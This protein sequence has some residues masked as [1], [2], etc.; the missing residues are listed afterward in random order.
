MHQTHL[1]RSENRIPA[2]KLLERQRESRPC[3]RG[4]PSDSIKATG[5]RQADTVQPRKRVICY[6]GHNPAHVGPG[7]GRFPGGHPG[8]PSIQ[9]FHEVPATPKGRDG[10][11]TEEEKRGIIFTLSPSHSGWLPSAVYARRWPIPRRQTRPPNIASGDSQSPIIGNLLQFRV[12]FIGVAGG[13]APRNFAF[14]EE[15]LIGI[16]NL[17]WK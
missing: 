14:R 5:Y 16:H 11:L 17:S 10:T 12:K 13:C 1:G 4:I 2:S 8:F 7:R 6:S 9:G 15:P 3:T